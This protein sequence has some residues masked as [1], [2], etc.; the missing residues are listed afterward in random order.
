MAAADGDVR[1]PASTSVLATLPPFP[2][3]PGQKAEPLPSCAVVYLR[4]SRVTFNARTPPLAPSTVCTFEEG[5]DDFVG[6]EEKVV[7]L[8]LILPFRKLTIQEID[9]LRT[10]TMVQWNK[11]HWRCLRESTREI[12][13]GG[14]TE[15][16]GQGEK[17]LDEGRR[18]YDTSFE[19]NPV[20]WDK[21]SKK[22]LVECCEVDT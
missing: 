13:R 16:Q 17:G 20:P 21:E 12:V 4:R 19:Q 6:G 1:P 11:R 3:P 9:R 8:A 18:H 2:V 7:L 14:R 22:D 15:E 5:G 10:S